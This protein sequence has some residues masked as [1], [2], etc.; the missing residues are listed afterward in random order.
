MKPPFVIKSLLPLT[1]I[2]STSILQ[3]IDLNKAPKDGGI[4]IRWKDRMVAMTLGMKQMTVKESNSKN[5]N[6]KSNCMEESPTVKGGG[7]FASWRDKKISLLHEKGGAAT[8]Q[9]F[10]EK[11]REK[12]LGVGTMHARKLLA[13][14]SL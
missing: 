11:M 12:S 7:V 3:P 14:S 1:A 6:V 4:I 5:S 10:K 2:S 9:S 13:S 8:K